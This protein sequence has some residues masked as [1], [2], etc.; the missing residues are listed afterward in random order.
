VTTTHDRLSPISTPVL[1]QAD[2]V[3]GHWLA[4]ALAMGQT[5]DDPN[6]GVP[7]QPQL[8][9]ESET[10]EVAMALAAEH[11]LTS[12]PLPLD[13]RI[14]LLELIADGLD[15]RQREVALQDSMANGNGIRTSRQMA[16]YLGPRVLSAR[17]QLLT[18]AESTEL[19]AAG[20]DVRL[21]RK[22]LGPAAV[23]APWNAP[24]F[25][26]I[27]KVASA[28]AAGCPVILKPSEW[29]PGGCQIVAEIVA[30]AMA[31]LDLPAAT[32]QLL[33][34]GAAVGAQLASDR[35]IRAVSFTGGGPGGRA[36][37]AAAA[38]HFTALQ[39]EL[40]G[41]NPALVLDDADVSSTAA[42]LADGMTK[43][44]GQWCEAPG[45]VIV[46]EGL[47]DALVDALV[48][49]LS[50]R[51]LG[52][53]LDEAT[54]V[55]PIA[56]RRHRD[57]L[58]DA[59]ES[60]VDAGGEALTSAP[61]PDLDGWFI[62]PTVVTGLPA[63]ASTRELFGPVVTV[64]LVSSTAEALLASRGPETGLAGFVF[65]A[66]LDRAIDVA[67]QV[68][69]GEVRVNGCNLADLADGSEQDF[70]D[71]SGVGGHGP[72]DM[73]RFF[74]GRSTVGVDDPDFPL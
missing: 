47:H 29:A 39:L 74:Q 37:A 56:Y 67:A 68:P 10:V 63:Q 2:L 30:S 54:D 61:L 62:S 8:A 31:E 58:Q 22:P 13:V 9:S 24:T 57:R 21:L 60:L 32:F 48:A 41:H 23:L 27:A 14:R 45:K 20:R 71:S 46:H 52:H 18:T 70:W 11:F 64:H 1:E 43:L 28:L 5:L 42:A 53:C 73:V 59:I 16:S 65:G 17:D 35:R 51:A 50:T 49:E 19:P 12:R 34:G 38:P 36:V 6:T 69:A 44:N 25:V 7:R 26:A 72:T 3:D 33:H 66:D 4:P 55:G 15:Q 40:G